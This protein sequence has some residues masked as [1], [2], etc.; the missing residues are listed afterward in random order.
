MEAIGSGLSKRE[1]L[2]AISFAMI[3]G[4]YASHRPSH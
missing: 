2:S 1:V 3:G 4:R